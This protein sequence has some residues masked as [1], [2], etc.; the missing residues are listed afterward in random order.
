MLSFGQLLDYES[1]NQ[2]GVISYLWSTYSVP[3][4]PFTS[5]TY[6]AMYDPFTGNWICNIAGI[7]A[8]GSMFGASTTV[9]DGMGGILIHQIGMGNSWMAIWNSTVCIQDTY[10]SNNAMLAP[11]GYWMWR[12]PLADTVNATTGYTLNVTLPSEVPPT[13]SVAGIDHENQVLLFGTNMAMLG[14]TP[15]PSP[16]D[17][18]FCGVSLKAGHEG[19]LLWTKTR[20]WPAGNVTIEMGPAGSGVYV[21]AVKETRQLY[22]YSSL[23]GEQLWGPSPSQG[24]WD[25]YGIGGAIAYGKLF[26]CGYNGILYCYDLETGDILWDYAAQGIGDESYYGNYPLNIGTIADNKIYVYSTEHSPT[27]PQWRVQPCAVST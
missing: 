20:P 16:A 10:P 7:P 2:H 24:A 21:I 9:T 4:G 25:M 27:K 14:Y 6:W 13:A 3:T 26:T 12:P 23:T 17:F 5:E 18:T 15:L 1:P 11:N 19:E 22:C 8:G